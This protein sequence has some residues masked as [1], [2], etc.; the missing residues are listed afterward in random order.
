MTSSLSGHSYRF[1]QSRKPRYKI[2]VKQ[3]PAKFLGV[4]AGESVCRPPDPDRNLIEESASHSSTSSLIYEG[5]PSS[6][7]CDYVSSIM[8]I[9]L[10]LVSYSFRSANH[11][12]R[13]RATRTGGD[14]SPAIM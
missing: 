11:L 4:L 9:A 3:H 12:V 2:I 13:N 14:V 7:S 6:Q 10:S 5:S 1:I 8:E